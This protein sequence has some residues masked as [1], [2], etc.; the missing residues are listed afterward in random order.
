MSDDATSIPDAVRHAYRELDGPLEVQL[1]S[2]GLLHRSLHVRSRG[3]EF[4]LQ[5]VSDVFAPEV[6]ANIRAVTT[7]LAARGHST[8]TLLATREGEPAASLG[9]Q[10]RWRLMSFLGGA[11]FQQ[12]ASLEQARSAGALVGRFHAALRDFEAPLAPMGIPYRD[13]P[14]YLTAMRSGL[15]AHSGHRLAARI[16]PLAERLLA[17][18][19]DLG[20]PPA[21]LPSR[22]I[23]GDLKLANV[24]FESAEGAG[25]DRALALIDLDTLMRAPLWM[26]LGDAWRSWCNPSGE[27]DNGPRFDMEAFEASYRGFVA[28]FGVP[29]SSAERESLVTAA[30]RITLELCSR[31]VTDALE[32]SYFAWDEAHYPAP[33]EHNAARAEGQWRLYEAQCTTREARAALL[34][35]EI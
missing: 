4:V 29:L 27:E 20:P 23:H 35:A 17:A 6:H 14:G 7:H 18:F 21:N 9:A 12:L 8:P 1:L 32:E 28:G 16:R 11:S 5:R 31:F 3:G 15:A 24:L 22:V 2:G 25:R 10:G 33:G 13:T 34:R 26:D 19:D 30:E